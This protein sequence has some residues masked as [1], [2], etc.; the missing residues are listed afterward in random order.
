MFEEMQSVGHEIREYVLTRCG[1][2]GIVDPLPCMTRGTTE[3]LPLVALLPMTRN[4][5]ILR[6]HH[7]KY[8][9]ACAQVAISLRNVFLGLHVPTLPALA[10]KLYTS[11]DAASPV[12]L[13]MMSCEHMPTTQHRG[14]R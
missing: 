1:E 14:Y 12:K 8:A 2:E 10:S 11:E 5:R 4:L 13:R 9:A 7:P 6:L 3:L